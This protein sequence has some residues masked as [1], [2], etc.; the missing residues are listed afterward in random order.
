MNT[1][2]IQ[3]LFKKYF[4]LI[5][6]IFIVGYLSP[7][8]IN[9]EDS[10][11]LLHDNMD[12]GPLQYKYSFI[13]SNP[14]YSDGIPNQRI[15]NGQGFSTKGVVLKLQHLPY[16]IMTPY[17]A[18]LLL[19]FLARVVAFFGMFFLL[20]LLRFK[21]LVQLGVSVLYSFLPFYPPLAFT[22]PLLP[23]LAWSFIIAYYNK[24][25]WQHW[26]ML[27]L[28]P[29]FSNFLM[30]PIFI[31]IVA[32]V[33][34]L[35]ILLKEK[36]IPWQ[37]LF[38]L[39]FVS[40]IYLLTEYSLL[41]FA[42]TGNEAIALSSRSEIV[43]ATYTFMEVLKNSF[44]SFIGGQY[45]VATYHYRLFLVVVFVLLIEVARP[46]F[47]RKIE[48]K[49]I[50]KNFF[51]GDE[52]KVH[53]LILLLLFSIAIIAGFMSFYHWK[54]FYA[55]VQK[56][57]VFKMVQWDRFY[58]LFP[59]LWTFVY[60][61]LFKLLMQQY[62]F[63]YFV[64]IGL[65]LFQLTILV[66]HSNYFEEKRK[67][68]PTYKEYYAEEQFDAIRDYIGLPQ[69]EYRVL[70][71]GMHPSIAIYNG[72]YCLD[73][74][75]SNYKLEYKNTFRNIIE[76]ELEKN[77]ILQSYF[78]YSG[79]RCYLFSAEL[80]KDFLYYKN[81]AKSISEFDILTEYIKKMKGRYILSAVNIK[82]YPKSNLKFLKVFIDEKSAWD[83]YLYKVL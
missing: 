79:I 78:D 51:L 12:Q 45:H 68:S 17:K 4:W 54:P 15:V 7:N 44:N 63:G 66:R 35:Y 40:I 6:L 34:M 21:V 33:L 74:Y 14:F 73:G 31:I 72:F 19:E 27:F 80:G 36:N 24:M 26:L 67:G 18:Y 76:K 57:G 3:D 16:Y 22:V 58:F 41:S 25:Q 30:A 8:I 1:I 2:V 64:V 28:V 53:R 29:F 82:N 46:F 70:S 52:Y 5:G 62:R 37:L 56:T 61:L 47:I 71:L 23:V 38:S 39:G 65:L 59:L 81:R 75:L 43:R 77:E 69:S 32:S 49:S 55:L 48:F 20:K 42:F 50:I 83:I 60:A 11:V 13:E 10:Y 9:E